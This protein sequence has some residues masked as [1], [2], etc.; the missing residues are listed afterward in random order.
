MGIENLQNYQ[1]LKATNPYGQYGANPNGAAFQGGM[2]G[3]QQPQFQPSQPKVQQGVPSTLPQVQPG[4][5]PSKQY[6]EAQ[7]VIDSG[8]DFD[9]LAREAQATNPF[10]KSANVNGE[11]LGLPAFNG[12][13]ELQPNTQDDEHG[14]HLYFMS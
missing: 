2:G 14:K 1:F 13:G 3:I 10:E 4:I 9:A 11:T 7:N 5:L 8:I 6:E 12:T